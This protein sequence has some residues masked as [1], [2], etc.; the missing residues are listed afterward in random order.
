MNG[1][2]IVVAELIY[3]LA[4]LIMFSFYC[5]ISDDLLEPISEGHKSQ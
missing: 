3:D 2:S 5:S 4:D 1:I